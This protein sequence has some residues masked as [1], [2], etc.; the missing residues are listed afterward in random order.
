ML[1]HIYVNASNYDHSVAF[2][3]PDRPTVDGNNIEACCHK[4][5]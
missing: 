1:D 2:S 4:P 3:A 5:E